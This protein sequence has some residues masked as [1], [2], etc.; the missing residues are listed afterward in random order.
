MEEAGYRDRW[1]YLYIS[2]QGYVVHSTVGEE[3]KKQEISESIEVKEDITG[4]VGT[5]LYTAPEVNIRTTVYNQG[6]PVF[7]ERFVRD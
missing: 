7:I 4:L 6:R 2:S 5:A 3:V 1:R